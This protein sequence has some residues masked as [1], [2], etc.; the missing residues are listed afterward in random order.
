MVRPSGWF[1]LIVVV[2][3]FVLGGCQSNMITAQGMTVRSA[4][5]KGQAPEQLAGAIAIENVSGGMGGTNASGVPEV[6]N[7]DLKTALMNSLQTAGLFS[8]TGSPRFKVKAK[9]LSF[10]GEKAS[11]T[12]DTAVSS[13]IHYTVTDTSGAV[14]FDEVIQVTHTARQGDS[15][16]ELT[17]IRIAMEGAARKNIATFIGKLSAT[18]LGSAKAAAS[19]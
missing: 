13:A 2:A 8:Q 10:L 15:A 7:D 16:I 18:Q 12:F 11:G 14:V 4:D 9:L 1:G 6:S 5:L 17:R 19:N 3:A